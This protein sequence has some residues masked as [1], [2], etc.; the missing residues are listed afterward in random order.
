[1]KRQRLGGDTGPSWVRPFF[2][3]VWTEAGG[4]DDFVVGSGGDGRG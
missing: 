3:T 1:M 4:L 2:N